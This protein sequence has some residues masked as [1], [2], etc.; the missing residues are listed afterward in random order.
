VP[1]TIARLMHAAVRYES[2]RWRT[3]YSFATG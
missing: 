2:N 1:L 3:R